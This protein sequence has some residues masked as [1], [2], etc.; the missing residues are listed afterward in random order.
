MSGKYILL[1][2]INPD[3]IALTDSCSTEA[4]DQSE[5]YRLGAEYF[6]SK[7]TGFTYLLR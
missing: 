1:I 3:D 2:V 4:K 5:I 6:F 7:S